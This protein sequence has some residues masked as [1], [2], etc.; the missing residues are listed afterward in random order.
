[1][2]VLH[3]LF[4]KVRAEVIRLL[5]SDAVRELHLRDLARN[6]GLAVRTLQTE[7]SK[8]EK[9]D[10]LVSRRDGNRLYFRANVDHPVFP[11]LQGLSLKT[12][13]LAD[14][15]KAALEGVAGIELAFV[16]GSI[17]NGSENAQ[18]DVDLFIVGSAGLRKLSP[19]LRPLA[20]ELRREFNPYV[21]SSES[22]ARKA[23][24]KDTF[25]MKVLE[26]PK[27]WIQGDADELAAM[28][29]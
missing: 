6:S 7:L 9:A 11:E 4:P 19:S 27:L 22:L 18:S 20:E 2:S 23:K 15:L 28:A 3:T 1:M 13:G 29:T 17:A 26:S 16:F 24:A 12:T 14:R 21:I 10:L 5:F 25:I 8:L